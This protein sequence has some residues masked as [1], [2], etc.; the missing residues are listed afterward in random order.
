VCVG[1]ALFTEAGV[2]HSYGKWI[3]PKSGHGERLWA[4]QV[5]LCD[6]ISSQAPKDV[7][8]EWPFHG[9]RRNAYG[10]LMQYCAMVLVSYAQ[11]F[12][13]ELP[14]ANRIPAPVVKRVLGF[15]R[16]TVAKGK[17]YDDNKRRVIRWANLTYGLRLRFVKNDTTKKRTQDDIAD[18]IAVG[19]AWLHRSGHGVGRDV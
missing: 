5:W 8:V 6:F 12:S 13:R 3:A 2:L 4:F 7:A 15:A 1:W 9:A 14:D 10:V 11:M 19:A 18:A 16:S 17:R